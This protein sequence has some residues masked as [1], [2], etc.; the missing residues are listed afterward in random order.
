MFTVEFTESAVEDLRYFR[1][2]DQ[3]IVVNAVDT[4]LTTEPLVATRNRKPLHPNNLSQWELRVGDF[5]VFYDV[6]ATASL[7]TVKAV[8]HKDHNR[9]YIRG[10]EYVL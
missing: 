9:L 8:G 10:L 4:Q 1:Q 2:Y 3:S 5:R 7:V 6:D